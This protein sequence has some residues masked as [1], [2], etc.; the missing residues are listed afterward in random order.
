MEFI[1][2]LIILET[3]LSRDLRNY[4]C[5]NRSRI[6][7]DVTESRCR[8]RHI[9][10]NISPLGIYIF[11]LRSVCHVFMIIYLIYL[12]TAVGLSPGGSTHLHTNSI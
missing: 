6:V 12:L 9:W 3:E 8:W 11:A 1:L 2:L 10:K 5:M 7:L 4:I